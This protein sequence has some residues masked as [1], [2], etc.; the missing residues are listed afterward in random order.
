MLRGKKSGLCY[1]W[2]E[3]SSLPSPAD[4][5]GLRQT[6]GLGDDFDAALQ[7]TIARKQRTMAAART[8]ASDNAAEKSDVLSYRTVTA[9]RHPT[10]KPLSLMVDLIDNAASRLN[11][12]LDP[13]MGSGTTGAAAVSLGRQFVGIESDPQYFA[14]ACKRIEQATKQQDLF[15]EKPKPIVQFGMFERAAE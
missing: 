12:I 2:E 3:G 14:V 11:T 8:M 9:G 1:R 15:I 7:R 13:F 4:A 5:A 6:L 10:E